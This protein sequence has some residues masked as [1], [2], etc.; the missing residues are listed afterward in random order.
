MR[1][2]LELFLTFKTPGSD[3][4]DSKLGQSLVLECGLDQAR[5]AALNRLVQVESHGDSLDD[6]LSFSSMTLEETREAAKALFDLMEKLDDH[7]LKRMIR[8]YNTCG[9]LNISDAIASIA[10]L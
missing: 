6:M 5:I 7:H 9:Y 1:K 10:F 8:C 2:V 3:G 4:L